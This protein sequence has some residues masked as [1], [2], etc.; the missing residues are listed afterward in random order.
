MTTTRQPDGIVAF[1]REIDPALLSLRRPP[2]F[3]HA[4]RTRRAADAHVRAAR[5]RGDGVSVY[6]SHL[7]RRGESFS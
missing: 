3:S 5:A 2:V 1:G 4:R 7:E 6:G